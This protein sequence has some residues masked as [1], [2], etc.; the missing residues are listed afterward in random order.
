VRLERSGKTQ[1]TYQ[2]LPAV[3]VDSTALSVYAGTWYSQELDTEWRIVPAGNRLRIE[4]RERPSGMLRPAGPDLFSDGQR[5]LAFTRR[6]GR[7]TGMTVSAG[8]VRGIG[9]IRRGT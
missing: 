9:F 7:V 4:V 6:G 8:R 5:H 1:D 3:T 2:R